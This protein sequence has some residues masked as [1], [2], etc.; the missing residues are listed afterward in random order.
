[1][2]QNISLLRLIDSQNFLVEKLYTEITSIDLSMHENRFVFAIRLQ[3]LYS[4]IVNLF[5]Q[6]VKAFENPIEKIDTFDQAL[7]LRMNIAIPKIRP[8]ILSKQSFNFLEKLRIFCHFINQA[9]DQEFDEQEF[10]LP[11]GA[12]KISYSEVESD[13]KKFRLFIQNLTEG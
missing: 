4:S 8:A 9:Y 10:S 7:L 13:L 12:L 6:T 11:Q 5:L 2:I 1:M 3:Q